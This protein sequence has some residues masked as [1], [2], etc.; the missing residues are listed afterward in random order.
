MP[1]ISWFLQMPGYLR[2]TL[3]RCTIYKAVEGDEQCD[4]IGRFLKVFGNKFA[5]KSIP[6]RLLTFGLFWKRS[7]N[8]KTSLDICIWSHWRWANR[9][10]EKPNKYGM[11]VWHNYYYY[12]YFFLGGGCH[13][14]NSLPPNPMQPSS[15]ST[16]ELH[17]KA[18]Q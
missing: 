16:K 15:P 8:V 9:S 1:S 11:Q 14:H 3:L 5:Y 6:K 18:Y 4:Q 10:A 7:I 17:N 12:Y 13:K 2:P